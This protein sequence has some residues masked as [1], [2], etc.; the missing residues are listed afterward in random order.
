TRPISLTSRSD[1]TMARHA[2]GREAFLQVVFRRGKVAPRVPSCVLQVKGALC[3]SA[4]VR[5]PGVGIVMHFLE[6]PASSV[7]CNPAERSL[8]LRT[9]VSLSQRAIQSCEVN[10][11]FWRH[12]LVPI[13]DTIGN[14]PTLLCPSF[15]EVLRQA[16]TRV[17]PLTLTSAF[18]A[19]ESPAARV[20]PGAAIPGASPNLT[21]ALR[22]ESTRLI[23]RTLHRDIIR[24]HAPTPVSKK[25]A[26]CGIARASW[27]AMRV[28]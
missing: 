26:L 1:F 22:L 5:H 18:R 19:A 17:G 11:G 3:R 27:T 2:M 15:G 12:L 4:L 28:R 10:F 21:F 13:D 25:K 9:A 14:V 8:A 6:A 20:A 24:A 7:D 23:R 16:L